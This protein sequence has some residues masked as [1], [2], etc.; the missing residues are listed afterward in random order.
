MFSLS[1]ASDAK[2]SDV[3]GVSLCSCLARAEYNGR[4]DLWR[5]YGISRSSRSRRTDSTTPAA[6]PFARHR[7]PCAALA[8]FGLRMPRSLSRTIRSRCFASTAK[9]AFWLRIDSK[10]GE[11]EAV[12]PSV[13]GTPDHL[14]ASIARLVGIG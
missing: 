3:G 2:P 13:F 14:V 9:S 11:L 10:H 5:S 12:P 6:R 4:R 8:R 1:D 7:R